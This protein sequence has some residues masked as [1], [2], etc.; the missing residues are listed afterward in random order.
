MKTVL[1][2]A[3][4]VLLFVDYSQAVVGQACSTSSDCQQGSECCMDPA[5]LKG[6]RKRQTNSASRTCQPL[7][8]QNQNCF[9]EQSENLCEL[10]DK[11]CR[12]H[13]ACGQGLRCQ[14]TGPRTVPYGI[15]GTCQ[16]Q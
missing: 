12:L 4:L 2:V 14:S 1:L 16:L 3:M 5:Q 6:R 8:T 7:G 9:V 11:F 15:P 13:C 10:G